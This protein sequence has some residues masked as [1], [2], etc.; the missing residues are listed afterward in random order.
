MST[1]PPESSASESSASESSHEAPNDVVLDTNVFV[2]AGFNLGS[3]AARILNAVRDGQLRMVWNEETRRKILYILRRIPPLRKKRVDNLF[4]Q[5]DQFT[6][7]TYPEN[8]ELI[9]DP[10]DRKF[11]ALAHAADAML[12][13]RDEHLLEYRQQLDVIVLT[14]SEYWSRYQE[15]K[16]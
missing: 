12:I 13:S 4:R 2:A 1:S 14:T 5:E 3:N 8:F 9:P 16:E 10:D 11:A 15:G 6:G 7:S